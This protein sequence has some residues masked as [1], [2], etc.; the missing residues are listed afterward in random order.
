MIVAGMWSQ[1]AGILLTAATASL[2]SWLLGAILMGL[3]TA[4]RSWPP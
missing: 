3:G 2:T 1:A 4:R